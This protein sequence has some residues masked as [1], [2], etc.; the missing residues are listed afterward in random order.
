[1]TKI[2]LCRAIFLTYLIIQKKIESFKKKL[3]IL[4]ARVYSENI[5]NFTN[6]SEFLEEDYSI[7][8]ED[9]GELVNE[10]LSNLKIIF[11]QYFPEDIRIN[12]EW[13]E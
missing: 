10:Y 7:K 2:C 4:K 5:D 11:N 9:I 13:I 6:V 3:R 8:F 1:M 12:Y